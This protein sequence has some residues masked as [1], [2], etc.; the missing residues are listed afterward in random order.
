[1]DSAS[2]KPNLFLHAACFSK[3][4]EL[5]QVV[6]KA[7]CFPM[8]LLIKLFISCVMHMCLWV[9]YSLSF[10]PWAVAWDHCCSH[11]RNNTYCS[12]L[13]TLYL[14]T[15]FSN[16]LI[17]LSTSWETWRE[18]KGRSYRKKADQM[19]KCWTLIYSTCSL[20][21]EPMLINKQVN[22]WITLHFCWAF[23]S[24]MPTGLFSSL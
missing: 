2:L 23:L 11:A 1:M 24:R 18:M 5:L 8:F 21:L 7:L 22:M 14:C 16:N 19:Q 3:Y 17:I 10:W 6:H 15:H 4:T 20:C 12:A 9:K 13:S